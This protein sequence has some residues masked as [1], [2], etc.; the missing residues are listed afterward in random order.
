MYKVMIVEDEIPIRNIIAR[1]IDWA[2]IGFELVYQADNGQMAL[3]YLETEKVDLIITDISMPFMDGLELCQHIRKLLPTTTIVI[4]TGHNEFDYAQKA[5]TLNVSNYLL[6]PITRDGFTKI[7][8]DIKAEMDEKYHTLND[9][10]FLR[11]QYHNSKEVLKNKFFINLM[12]GYTQ[13]Y[14]LNDEEILD[15]SI[16]S[17]WYS[18]GILTLEDS[19]EE[20]EGFWGKDRPLLE[21]AVYNLTR[22]LL[23]QINQDIVFF[24]PG[25]QICMIYKMNEEKNADTINEIIVCLEDISVQIE[26]HFKMSATIGISEAYRS[27]EDLSFAYEE[28]RVALE[29]RVLEGSERVIAKSSVEKKS[30]FTFRK[31]EEQLTRLEYSIKVGDTSSLKKI[32]TYVFSVINYENVTINEFRTFLMQLTM[33]IFK[34]YN[35]ISANEEEVIFDYT[36]FSRVFEMSDFA[37]IQSYYQNLCQELSTK[38]QSVRE[39]EEKGHVKEACAYIKANYT[40][41]LL[42]LEGLCKV[43]YLSPGHFSRLFKKTM[44]INFVDYLTKVRMDQAKYLLANT[45]LKMY[46]ISRDIGYDDPNYFSYNFK[47]R[48]RMTP[49]EWRKRGED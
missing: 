34:S 46:E 42:S 11:K 20:A 7:L 18:V 27:L 41:P 40:D 9:L 8:T 36:L 17:R 26:S 25:N 32:I 15:V 13:P 43:L 19:K 44:G 10:V 31:I 12:F 35:D 1:M 47:K 29:Y 33:S 3:A 39:D 6:K 4:L 21:F 37:E 16:E 14:Y 5:I 30:S 23:D 22:E 28:A 24:G 45:N 2:E 48:E 38:I 49:S